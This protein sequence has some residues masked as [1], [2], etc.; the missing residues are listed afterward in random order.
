MMD[1]KLTADPEEREIVEDV[2]QE[3]MSS[4][5]QELLS[6]SLSLL[7]VRLSVGLEYPDGRDEKI[8]QEEGQVDPVNQ[9]VAYKSHPRFSRTKFLSVEVEGPLPSFVRRLGF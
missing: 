1:V 6:R 4:P 5:C 2:S 8:E 7:S 9:G 3:E